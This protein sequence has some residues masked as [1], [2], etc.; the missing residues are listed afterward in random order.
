[1]PR[2][3]PLGDALAAAC[4]ARGIPARLGF[5]DVRNH[6]STERMRQSVNDALDI[7][8]GRGICTGVRWKE[9]FSPW[10]HGKFVGGFDQ[11]SV[12]G[13]ITGQHVGG[14]VGAPAQFPPGL[15]PTGN[16]MIAFTNLFA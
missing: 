8:G 4:R 16:F 12:S 9:E 5:A 11:E 13:S 2:P 6:L 14:T 10:K 1:M 7:H 15:M 3:T